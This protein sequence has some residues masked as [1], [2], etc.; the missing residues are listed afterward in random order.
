MAKGYFAPSKVASEYFGI[1]LHDDWGLKDHAGLQARVLCY[2]PVQNGYDVDL[3][4][5]IIAPFVCFQELIGFDRYHAALGMVSQF[6]LD[7]IEYFL[8][9][10]SWRERPRDIEERTEALRR[11][12]DYRD[13]QTGALQWVLSEPTLAKLERHLEVMVA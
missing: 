10:P 6:N 5:E 13:G 1:K 3:V 11:R 4:E 7:D 8:N 2:G 9:C 12:Y